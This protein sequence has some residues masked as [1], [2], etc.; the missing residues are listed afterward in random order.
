MLN[1]LPGYLFGTQAP[2]A[3]TV[4]LAVVVA[5]TMIVVRRALGNYWMRGVML[6]IVSGLIVGI[7]N[8]MQEVAASGNPHLNAE[9]LEWVAVA[10]VAVAVLYMLLAMAVMRAWADRWRD[11]TTLL[12]AA[13]FAS[14][15]AAVASAEWSRAFYERAQGGAGAYQ[16]LSQL[17]HIALVTAIVI[18]TLK[19]LVFWWQYNR[20]PRTRQHR[21]IT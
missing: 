11:V 16:P 6:A 9:A 5:V 12:L 19:V 21:A 1:P 15:W 7:K 14:V 10:Q 2:N 18:F 13:A 4:L 8:Y 3:T 20:V 17:L